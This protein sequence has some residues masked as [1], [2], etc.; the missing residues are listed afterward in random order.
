MRARP[1]AEDAKTGVRELL[2]REQVF[3]NKQLFKP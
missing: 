3:A 1:I 2:V